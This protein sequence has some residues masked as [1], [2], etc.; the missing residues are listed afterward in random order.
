MLIQQLTQEDIAFIKKLREC[1]L[2]CDKVNFLKGMDRWSY[3]RLWISIV[4]FLILGIGLLYQSQAITVGTVIKKKNTIK[5]KNGWIILNQS[6]WGTKSNLK[7]N[8][9]GT[10]VLT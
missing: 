4:S 7:Q 2:D 5:E 1:D 3:W 8:S 10:F 6:S 9:S